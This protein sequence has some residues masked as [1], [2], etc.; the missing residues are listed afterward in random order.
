MRSALRRIDPVQ[1]GA[2]A[3]DSGRG[4]DVPAAALHAI[5]H[6]LLGG[7]PAD[8]AERLRLAIVHGDSSLFARV[9]TELARHFPLDA[10]L[11]ATALARLQGG[12]ME[13]ARAS[14]ARLRARN[15][16][17]S[18]I[19]RHD[20]LTHVPNRAAVDDAMTTEL[21]RAHRYAQPFSVL[22]LDI[23]HF[24]RVNDRHGHAVGDRVLREVATALH[25]A[26]RPGDALGRYGGEEFVV[27]L[28]NADERAALRT[29]ERLRRDIERLPLEDDVPG[30]HVTVSI[31]V[32]TMHPGDDVTL[33]GLVDRADRAMLEAKAAGRNMICA[34]PRRD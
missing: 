34:S 4:H 1:L 21:R 9:A 31:G 23:D 15:R 3:R 13:D 29:A 5:A 6:H 30:L 2:R 22:F 19:A 14:E 7:D 33:P 8:A 12:V 25:R 17:L 28:V 11:V 16:T 27:G 18:Q 32:A 26:L 24:K 20:S 10:G